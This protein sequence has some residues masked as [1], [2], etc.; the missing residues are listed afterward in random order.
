MAKTQNVH[1]MDTKKNSGCS[2]DDSTFACRS[3]IHSFGSLGPSIVS[4]ET[5]QIKSS[6]IG[7]FAVNQL[8]NTAERM[9]KEVPEVYITLLQEDT[10]DEPPAK[11]QRMEDTAGNAKAASWSSLASAAASSAIAAG[12]RSSKPVKLHPRSSK[13]KTLVVSPRIIVPSRKTDSS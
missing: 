1:L 3:F 4:D 6:F 8:V 10:V 7:C 13:G 2:V 11:K 9:D 5:F 12:R